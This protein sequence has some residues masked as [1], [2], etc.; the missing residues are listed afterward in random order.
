MALLYTGI[1]EAGYGPMLGPLCVASA[2]IRV[3][4][5]SAGEPAPDLWGMLGQAVC[6]S[7]REAKALVAVG[8]SKELKLSNSSV[9]K[10]PLHHLERGVL[11]FL[12]TRAG[13]ERIGDDAS[14]GQK[15]GARFEPQPWYGGGAMRLPLG[16]SAEMLAID[17]NTLRGAMARAGVELVDLR[18]RVIGEHE[19]NR[20]YREH[21][22]K[23]AATG[24]ALCEL[25]GA[26]REHHEA[27]YAS[28]I[29]CDRQSGRT[30][31][32]RLL[33]EVFADV[34]VEE[35]SARASRYRCDGD[36]GV[37]LTPGADGAYFPVALAS[38]AA[39]L[40]RELAM[41]R[42]NRYWSSRIPELKPTAGY[43]QDARR[44]L[45]DTRAYI[46]D[47]ERATMVRL[48]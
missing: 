34:V 23:A 22:S 7:K 46:S 33:G 24:L 19:F 27:G 11:A 21:K 9:S 38:M 35:E 3:E 13:G 41:M 1:D 2:T 43:V 47:E 16:V 32:K 14:L 45:G 28:R 42:F 4:S 44:W 31:Y 26:A 6:R 12:G 10:H 25:I 37:L 29:V 39:K 8:D 5:W 36:T 20:I 40:V 30:R 18:V 48:A 15:L 17:I